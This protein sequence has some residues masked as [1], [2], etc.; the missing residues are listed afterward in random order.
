MCK[1][2][3]YT[4]ILYAYIYIQ[5]HYYTEILFPSGST[6][7]SRFCSPFLAVKKGAGVFIVHGGA[8]PS[9]ELSSWMDFL[10]MLKC[11]YKY[12]GLLY[13]A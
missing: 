7:H 11:G 12:V 9:A 13:Y 6:E 10:P 2:N 1:F 8:V 3:K 4:Y 5:P